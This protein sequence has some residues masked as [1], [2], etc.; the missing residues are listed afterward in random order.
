MKNTLEI[1]IWWIV[2]EL[3]D[4]KWKIEEK[5]WGGERNKTIDNKERIN[6]SA[7]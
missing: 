2:L 6:I 3:R 4:L 1:S 7:A 5:G